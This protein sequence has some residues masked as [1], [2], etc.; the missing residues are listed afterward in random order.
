M[1]EKYCKFLRLRRW[2]AYRD[3]RAEVEV[4]KAS[5]YSLNTFLDDS[6][7]CELMLIERTQ[8]NMVQGDFSSSTYPEYVQSLCD[9]DGV[10]TFD[11]LLEM[12]KDYFASLGANVEH[13]LVD[14]LQDVG[15]LE[16]QFVMGLNAEH[17]FLVGDDWQAI[18]GFKGGNVNIFM[19][20][21][22]NPDYTTYHLTT[23]YR[24]STS[25]LDTA[26]IVIDQVDNKLPKEIMPHRAESKGEVFISNKGKLIEFLNMIKD[27]KDYREWFILTRSNKELYEMSSRCEDLGIPFVTFKREGLSLAELQKKMRA[28]KVKIL[29]VHTSKGLEAKNV[30]LY[31]AFP[32]HC[33]PYRMNAEERKVMYVGVTRAEDLLYILN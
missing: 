17:Y 21:V 13:V 25:I 27:R 28:N 1:I 19:N 12:A 7:R 29:T 23:N 30:L 33:P 22:T 11:Q 15:N 14:E 31:G 26:Q 4:G 32:L 3:L 9:K 5:E 20:L 2:I 16:Y 18:Y 24:N 8:K 10:I 6:E